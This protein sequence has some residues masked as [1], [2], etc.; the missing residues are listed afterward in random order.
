MSRSVRQYLAEIGRRG[1]IRSR[2]AL[3]A[4][5][6]RTMV[7][8]R[9]ERK[10]E[11]EL[12]HSPVGAVIVELPGFDLVRD[13]LRDLAAG[14]ESDAA[15]LVSIAAPRLRLLGIPVRRPLPD[16][17]DALFARLA[18]RLG[19][20]AHGAYNA[21]VRRITSFTRAGAACAS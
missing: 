9:E 20:G 3:S 18:E 2:R 7:A 1:G 12:L 8:A 21:L 14:R 15:L 19:D 4:E 6:A 5:Q 13:G 17:E 11:R 10:A 16:P